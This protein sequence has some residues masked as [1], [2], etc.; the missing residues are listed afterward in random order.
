MRARGKVLREPDVG[1]GLLMIDGQQFR[2]WLDGWHSEIAPKPG[3]AVQVELNRQLEVVRV[4]AVPEGQPKELAQ[5]PIPQSTQKSEARTFRFLARILA[6][7]TGT[8]KK[9]N[10]AA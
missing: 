1:P 2:F 8:F 4:T 3:L 5:T 6:R 7:L 10:P 9:E